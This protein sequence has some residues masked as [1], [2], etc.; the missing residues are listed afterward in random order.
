MQSVL[1]EGHDS[2]AASSPAGPGL[3]PQAPHST[4]WDVEEEREDDRG[5]APGQERLSFE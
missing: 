2:A 5:D 4:Q 3:A 1:E